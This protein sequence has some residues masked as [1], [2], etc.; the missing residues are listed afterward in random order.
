MRERWRPSKKNGLV[1][2]AT[3]RQPSSLAMRATIGRDAGT[4]AA[5]FAAGHEDHVRAFDG[6]LDLVAR[7]FGGAASEVGVHAGA[8]AASQVLADMDALL[9]ER[10]VQILAVGIDGDEVDA[11]DLAGDHVVDGVIAGAAYA[12]DFDAGESFDV[13]SD[14]GHGLNSKE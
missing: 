6:F 14:V 4:G 13:W 12:E 5:A 1:T 2:T 10:A 8:Q 3:V 9:G 7:L 11:S